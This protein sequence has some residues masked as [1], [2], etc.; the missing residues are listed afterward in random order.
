[1]IFLISGWQIFAVILVAALPTFFLPAPVFRGH[2][3]FECVVGTTLQLGRRCFVHQK[4]YAEHVP[5]NELAEYL[6]ICLLYTSP[7]P[8][9]A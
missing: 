9:D 1:M 7:S 6:Y 2:T 3:V 5:N 8:R 4:T